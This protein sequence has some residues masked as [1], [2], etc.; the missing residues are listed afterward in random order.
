MKQ[1]RSRGGASLA[2]YLGAVNVVQKCIA[3]ICPR[4]S[5]SLDFYGVAAFHRQRYSGA[6]AVDG[7]GGSCDV[8]EGDIVMERA[9][10]DFIAAQ[11]RTDRREAIVSRL[12]GIHPQSSAPAGSLRL[13]YIF[14]S[15]IK[16]SYFLLEFGKPIKMTYHWKRRRG[17]YFW[18]G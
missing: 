11:I 16:Y 17:K 6:R 9:G 15:F 4:I 13:V 2:A 10:R 7:S 3:L 12:P 8:A 18:A 14:I 5:L 1:F